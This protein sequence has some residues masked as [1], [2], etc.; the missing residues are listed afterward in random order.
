MKNF[1]KFHNVL[2]GVSVLPAL[3]V[4]PVM[5]AEPNLLG[6]A[7]VFGDVNW[8]NQNVA[9]GQAAFGGRR[10]NVWSGTQYQNDFPQYQMAGRSLTMSDS[11][12]YVGPVALTLR[13]L[14]SDETFKFNYQW[15]VNDDP[16]TDIDLAS[17]EWAGVKWN[18][19]YDSVSEKLSQVIGASNAAYTTEP[20]Y[21]MSRRDNDKVAG[22]LLF[23][24]TNAMI[25]GTTINADVIAVNN[26]STLTFVKQD[27]S[28]LGAF[29]EGEI[30]SDGITTL[31][32]KQ[33]NID[34]ARMLV[35]DGAS[36]TI[37][38]AD[39][40]TFAN[41]VTNGYGGILYNMGNFTVSDAKFD[42]NHTGSKGYGGAIFNGMGLLTLNNV[43][44]TN[45]N[46]DWDGGAI[47]SSTSN[48]KEAE[49]PDDFS[50]DVV[51]E[52]TVRAYWASKNGFDAKNKMIITNSTFDHNTVNSYSGGALG[53]YSDAVIQGSRFTNNNAGGNTPADDTDG[54]GAIYAGGWARLDVND[55]DFSD[56][57]SNY[58]GA[59]ATTRAGKENGVYL[60]ISNSE[61]INNTATV[62]GGAISNDF[63]D[64]VFTDVKF[65]D[66]TA[67]NIGG[68]IYNKNSLTIAARNKDVLFSG[69]TA[70]ERPNDIYN[71]GSLAL[72]AAA[73]RLISLVGG[74][75]GASGTLDIVGN[76]TVDIA[77]AL[78][79][80]TVTHSAGEL[81]LRGVDLTGSAVAVGQNAI[82]NTIDNAVNDYS[83]F[84]TLADGASVR[85]DAT[86][87]AAD[88]FALATDNTVNLTS[89]NLLSDFTGAKTNQLTSSGKIAVA[90]TVK[91]YTSTGK[92]EITGSSDNSGNIT[93]T[94][95][96]TG[97]LFAAADDTTTGT[98]ETVTYS[99]TGNDA[100]VAN[101]AEIKNADL[102]V[103]GNGATNQVSLDANLTVGDTS[104]LT[105]ED[106][107]FAGAG[108]I[109]NKSGG[110]LTI[111]DSTIATNINNAGVLY[112]DPT[113]YSAVVA[114][115]GTA[116]F[117]ADTFDT[118][119]TL[120][121]TGI[122]NLLNGVIF[123]T[124]AKITGNGVTNLVNGE[125][126]FNNT[127]S[128]NTVK[129][130]KGADFS[131]TLTGTLDTRNDT[132]DDISG[133]VAGGNLYVDAKLRGTTGAIDSLASSTGATIKEINITD[134][135]YGTNGSYALTVGDASLAD[136]LRIS[137]DMN[138][139]T[140]V[141]KNG[142]DVVFS[143]KLM[144][145]SGMHAQLG[146]WEDGNYIAASSAYDATTDAYT[147]QGQTVGAALTALDNAV[148][149]KVDTADI[150]T[151][152]VDD[153][154]VAGGDAKVLSVNAFQSS[155]QN[156]MDNVGI[157][158]TQEQGFDGGLTIGDDFGVTAAGV[159]TL[160]ATTVSSLTVAG[161]TTSGIDNV[162][163]A[164][165]TNLITSGAVNTA[166]T[167]ALANGGNAY[168]TS[169][170]VA[171]AISANA[172]NAL[173]NSATYTSGTIGAAI[174][175]N[176][177]QIAD[178]NAVLGTIDG[179]IA[180]ADATTI[181]DNETPYHG[182][183]AVGTTVENHLLALDAAIGDMRGFAATDNT[184]NTYA[185]NTTS[186]ASNLVALDGAAQS[187]AQAI[188]NLE[189]VVGH[190]SS[191]TDVATG[192]FANVEENASAIATLNGDETVAN[193][194]ANKI[195]TALANSGFE[196]TT[197]VNAT[198]ISKG[199]NAT[200]NA[201]TVQDGTVGKAIANNASAIADINTSDV[202]QS[203]IDSAKVAQIAINA[204][205]IVAERNRATN[206]EADLRG[207]FVSADALTLTNA[208]N[209]AA[210]RDALTLGA[211]NAYTDKQVEK[212]DKNL[213]AGIAGA[214]ALSSVAV[215]DVRRGEM[216][217]GAGYGYFNGQSAGAFGA[218]MGLTN[219]WSVNAGAGVSGY[220]VS[221]RAGTNYK[222]KLF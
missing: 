131:G 220:D 170:N 140:K 180:G 183:L 97:G 58:G 212:L 16:E 111:L 6:N 108:T 54:G 55:S 210:E 66:N 59:I 51:N 107:S 110:V 67:T 10:M 53:V 151:A 166:I 43:T 205:D 85:A 172:Q 207:D 213:S 130:A 26:E 3:L 143:D 191:G 7:F 169:E 126:V 14:G 221:F 40:A 38:A 179:L 150:Y 41:G 204:N 193:S 12:I 156:L 147:A 127:V 77:N 31:N 103:K 9:Y 167:N 117:D 218:A 120:N 122:V 5:G 73:G 106:A 138:Y 99:V 72:D 23:N 104:S 178:I 71:T 20:V 174:K 105:I 168:Q 37:N 181:S 18:D 198:I 64:A 60:H 132:I 113:T 173:Y 159:A 214:V 88:K 202:M 160:G 114:N 129:L 22:A 171:G 137:G 45:N 134:S 177:T 217:I 121:N 200:Y 94:N 8:T 62:A 17:D 186:V 89:L 194:V 162:V 215:S 199:Q 124:G 161:R 96:G 128:S 74:V 101:S 84:I 36:V 11:D 148:A 153:T 15:I 24:N 81:H 33:V 95:A 56:N 209:F 48:I 78:K 83:S 163:T 34:G 195:A 139:F 35:K 123:N 196:T 176:A 69:N 211:A 155:I 133:S 149:D 42:N 63:A 1:H 182:N 142:N 68:A 32:A 4:L 90:D 98:R 135:E 86:D 189:A 109:E 216:S 82:I 49:K 146:D 136:D 206:A 197:N 145:T 118:T 57:S 47:S 201:N 75:D 25:D 61:F 87:I 116:S 100:T 76:G 39:E 192:L 152:V 65:A 157:N 30:D 44:F 92:Y 112:S 154:P 50:A 119:A 80:Q 125:T 188:S 158:W 2:L 46:A 175:S 70:N 93:V 13:E 144:N 21:A 141:S 79:N 52:A 165:S 219:R 184:G 208:K 164:D 187:N 28:K 203:G 185:T 19:T 91:T 102:I 222:F 190:A 115:S 27:H 29:L